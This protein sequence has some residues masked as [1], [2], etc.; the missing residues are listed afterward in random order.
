MDIRDAKQ[1]FDQAIE[2]SR[3][4]SEP[5]SPRYAGNFMYMYHDVSGMAQF[6]HRDTREYLRA[7]RRQFGL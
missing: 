1:A 5:S 4:S 7:D 6:K 3:L 2:D